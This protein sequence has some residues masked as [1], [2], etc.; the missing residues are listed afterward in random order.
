MT[1]HVMQSFAASDRGEVFYETA[2]AYAGSLWMQGLPARSLLLI[3]R[4]LGAHLTGQEPVLRQWPLPYAAVSWI[5]RHRPDAQF[6]GNPRRHYQ[7]LA[8]RMVPPRREQRAW[9]AWAC[10]YLAMRILPA[11]CFPADHLQLAT[12]DIKE[13]SHHLIATQLDRV[14]I[15]GE[16]HLWEQAIRD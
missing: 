10:W 7:H 11:E 4:G 9:R 8:T 2:L 1:H 16:R 14:G 3:N 12:E 6:I 13:P 5:L 15:P